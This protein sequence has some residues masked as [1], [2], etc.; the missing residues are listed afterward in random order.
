MNAIQ[1]QFEDLSVMWSQVTGHL[2]NMA[3]RAMHPAYQRIIGMGLAVVPYI[4][5]RF[6]QGS[7][8]DWFWA[9][10]AI[11]GANP[12][13]E[14]TAGKVDQ[15]AEAWVR[16]GDAHGYGSTES[17]EPARLVVSEADILAWQY[18]IAEL[19]DDAELFHDNEKMFDMLQELR[20]FFADTYQTGRRVP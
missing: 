16:W 9:L 18:R 10:T 3:T 20:Q 2:S 4:L 15:M 17:V 11:T 7:R 19:F 12:I 1:Q 8:E 5:E 13:T 6:R 14:G